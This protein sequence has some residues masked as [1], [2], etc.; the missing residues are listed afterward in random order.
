M[1]KNQRLKNLEDAAKKYIDR[2][3]KI[4]N[5]EYDFLDKILS[6]RGYSKVEDQN[7][8]S[9]SDLLINS[10]KDFLEGK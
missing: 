4:L 7:N 8:S 3:K 6:A 10:L 9:A 2:E 1:T 5:A